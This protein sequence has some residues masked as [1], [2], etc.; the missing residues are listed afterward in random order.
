[1]T[2]VR[3]SRIMFVF[4]LLKI[5]ISG[6][7]LRSNLYSI[8]NHKDCSG[9]ISASRLHLSE[10]NA[11]QDIL[12]IKLKIIKQVAPIFGYYAIML[13]PIYGIGLLPFLGSM[14][15]F[16]SLRNRGLPGIRL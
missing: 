5:C 8:S 4:V 3:S 2:P 6:L 7:G 16:S 13:A 14:T 10:K 15:E 12:N 1:M 9:I 11:I